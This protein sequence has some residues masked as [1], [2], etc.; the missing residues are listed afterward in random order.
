MY[1][2]GKNLTRYN[3]FTHTHTQTHINTYL[4]MY[5]PNRLCMFPMEQKYMNNYLLL[6]K[7]K[8]NLFI[9]KPFLKQ[10]FK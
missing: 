1:T 3:Q 5:C 9:N 4:L 7:K 8:L 10:S 6:F 2:P